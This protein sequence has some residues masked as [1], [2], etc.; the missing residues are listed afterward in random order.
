ML[1]NVG[2]GLGHTL[3]AIESTSRGLAQLQ[4]D[5]PR[6]AA[7]LDGSV[8]VLA[9]AVQTCMRRHGICDAFEQLK[10]LTRGQEI[11]KESLETFIGSL[12][13]PAAERQRLLDLKPADYT[14]LAAQLAREI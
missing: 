3:I 9:E 5:P 2:V 6:I 4:A 11:T 12:D 14:G 13:I 1:R 8:E 10:A 7:D